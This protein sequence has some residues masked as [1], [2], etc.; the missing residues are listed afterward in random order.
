MLP[1]VDFASFGRGSCGR[2]TGGVGGRPGVLN[3]PFNSVIPDLRCRKGAEHLRYYY[4]NKA[5]P[6]SLGTEHRPL[7]GDIMGTEVKPNV[8]RMRLT[9]GTVI[10]KRKRFDLAIVGDS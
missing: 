7:P 4:H 10:H 3:R 5:D 9:K 2:G 1:G 6:H 8:E